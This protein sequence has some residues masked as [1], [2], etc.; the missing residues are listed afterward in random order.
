M[1]YDVV[2]FG[3]AMLRLSPPHFGRLEQTHSLDVEIGGSELNVA[4]GLS[5]LGMPAAW[6]SKLPNN[7]L[8][9]MVRNRARELGVDTSQVLFSD[10]GRQGLYFVEYGAAPRA[11]SVLYDRGNSAVS[12]IQAGEVDWKRVLA[13]AKLFHVS[14]ITPALSASAAETTAVAMKAAKE[15]GC[16]VSYDLN[17]RKKLWSPA[18]A[19]SCQ[20][21]LMKLVDIL[22]T[23]EEDTGIVFGIRE[24]SY[25]KVA[26]SLA[27]VFGIKAV[28]ITLREDLSVWK[29]NWTA[30]AYA[31]GKIYAD[32]IYTV[33]IVDRVGAGDSFTAGFIYGYLTGD[34][35]K[36]VKYGNA[37][38]ALKHT[39]PGDFN[40]ST[41]EEVE[42][43]IKGAGLR[44]S[45]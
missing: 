5:R 10:K 13:K 2:T 15:A 27:R 7:A 44:I 12:L 32:R 36:G 23:T 1:M 4:V 31:D 26:E 18:E 38:A 34:A 14:G 41:L 28:A 24:D 3:E 45:R 29:N 37:L 30:I 40:W 19:K 6:I 8:G 21:P 25:Q 35:E 17:Y 33:E 39:M 43:Q 20:A 16:L 9:K 42:A 11:S 22:T